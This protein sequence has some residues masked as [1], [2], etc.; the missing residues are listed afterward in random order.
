MRLDEEELRASKV[1]HVSTQTKVKAT[2]VKV[3]VEDNRAAIEAECK[4]F[5]ER[6]HVENLRR[7]YLLLGR[8]NDGFR[9]ILQVM[10]QK[11][12]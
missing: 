7:M 10:I 9:V 3:L 5:I 2:V 12:E 8:I 4:G 6:Q 1:L 11:V